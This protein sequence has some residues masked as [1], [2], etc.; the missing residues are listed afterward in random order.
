LSAPAPHPPVWRGRTVVWLGGGGGLLAEDV[1]A[2]VAL[3]AFCWGLLLY[4]VEIFLW[5]GNR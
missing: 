1:A 5:G 4:D 2:A 3:A